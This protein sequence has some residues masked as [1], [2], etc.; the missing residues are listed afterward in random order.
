M[1]TSLE[2][3]LKY[4]C[5]KINRGR[6]TLEMGM[7]GTPHDVSNI[8]Y[9]RERSEEERGIKRVHNQKG[10]ARPLNLLNIAAWLVSTCLHPCP[11]CLG[12]GDRALASCILA[13]CV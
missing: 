1:L 5:R 2:H 11:L 3:G 7:N 9:L 6:H 10:E 8:T 12:L 4:R 13:P